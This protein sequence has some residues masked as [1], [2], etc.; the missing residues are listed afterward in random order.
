MSTIFPHFL[1]GL[2]SSIMNTLLML[3]L[4][5]PKYGKRVANLTMLGIMGVNLIAAL[6]CYINN[7]LSLLM[8]LNIIIF[9]ITCFL[10]RP[11]FKD[12][13]MQWLFS[14]ITVLN[15]AMCIV[16]LSFSI[17]R[18]MPF[19]IYANTLIRFIMYALIIFI[20]RRYLHSEYRKIVTRWNVF[21]FVALTIFITFVYY[22]TRGNDIIQTLIEQTI[23]L[24]LLFFITLSVYISLFQLIKT[25]SLEYE[26]REDNL[27][28]K[29]NQELLYL[30]ASDME[31]RIILL[32]E[33]QAQNSI[34]NHDRRHFN[35]TLLELL[36]DNMIEDAIEFLKK[37]S[38]VQLAQV[39][40]YCENTVVNAATS[41][42]IGI[43]EGK[44]IIAEVNIDIPNTLT[45]DSIELA[46]VISNLLE[47]AINACEDLED[48]RKPEISF[49][50]RNVGRLVVEITNPCHKS[51]MLDEKG[52]PMAKENSHGI[53][54]KSVL[55]FAEKNDS[56]VI[57]QIEEGIFSVRMII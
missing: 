8:K 51:I 6:F 22:L 48:E 55:A 11:L 17:S 33:I 45:V 35:N 14:Y 4:L 57:Y 16:I 40:K 49:N 42:Y 2:V 1:R 32:N 23:P 18:F 7:D 24:H 3:S 28:M 15:I 39:K 41:Y 5:Q 9:T 21:F 47:N 34:S 29:N 43:A 38:N 12:S 19:S 27:R 31:D 36:K 37:Q 53:G 50:C 56:E 44:G 10:I 20:I 30:S 46:M 26:L 25:I 54:T 52:Y 13:L